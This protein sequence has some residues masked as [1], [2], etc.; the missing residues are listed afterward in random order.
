MKVAESEGLMQAWLSRLWYEGNR[1]WVM[2]AL[3]IGFSI[4][5]QGGRHIPRTGPVLL[6]ANHQ[7]FIDPIAIGLA[8]PRQLFYLARKTLFKQPQFGGFLRS[9]GCVPVDQEG[10]AREGLKTTLHLLKE[11]K[12]VLVFPEG[13]R[14]WNGRMQ[15]LKPGIHLL[16]KRSGVP[17]V[18]VG[19]AG[20]FAAYPRTQKLPRL[21]PPFLPATDA[22]V[23]VSVGPAL[24]PRGHIGWPRERVLE[25]L[26]KKISEQIDCAEHLRRQSRRCPTC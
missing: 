19:I 5:F 17:V 4:R 1:C 10:F 8:T 2:A 12:A 9:V 14:T 7:S 25:E 21:A 16:M 18:P 24:E 15:P 23:A 22:T 6:V 3:S 20:A 11:G 26:F 13:E